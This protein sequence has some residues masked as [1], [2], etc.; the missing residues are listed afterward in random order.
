MNLSP[1]TG[2]KQRGFDLTPMIDVVLQLIIFFLF[3]SQFSQLI[4]S[5]IDLPEQPGEKN[6]AV[7]SGLVVVDVRQDGTILI[8]NEPVSLDG[9]VRILQ[10]EIAKRGGDSAAVELL[11]RADRAAR[12]ATVNDLV[13]RLA[14]L[15]VR[16]W[17]VGTAEVPGGRP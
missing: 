2:R 3:T 12:A 8:A 10:A 4:R 13:D 1:R 7:A 11:I 14:A 15:G 5:P 9:A 16:R 6:A 17:Q